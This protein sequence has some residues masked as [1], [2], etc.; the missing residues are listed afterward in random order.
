LPLKL[1]A[2]SSW[3]PSARVISYR[4][5]NSANAGRTEALISPAAVLD[6]Q[7]LAPGERLAAD[8][9]TQPAV[10]VPQ[11]ERLP[12]ERPA[13]VDEERLATEFVLNPKVRRERK[14]LLPHQVPHAR[15]TEQPPTAFPGR[16]LGW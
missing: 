12:A 10:G 11:R 14:E 13:A 5:L 6:S 15:R 4:C 1:P 9:G 8:L 16:P 3:L 7:R 2:A